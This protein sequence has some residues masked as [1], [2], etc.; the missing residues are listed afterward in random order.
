MTN[1]AETQKAQYW[2]ITL[3]NGAKHYLIGSARAA[4][5]IDMWGDGDK[6]LRVTAMEPCTAEE[7][8]EGWGIT[9]DAAEKIRR[10]SDESAE[11][12]KTRRRRR[13]VKNIVRWVLLG[14]CYALYFFVLIAQWKR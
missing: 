6:I 4:A 1:A 7:I 12:I 8:A 14:A 11:K 2:R 9:A 10:E 3:W 13:D 5:M